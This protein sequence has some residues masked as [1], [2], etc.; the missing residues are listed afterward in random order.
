[1]GIKGTR[2][3]AEVNDESKVNPIGEIISIATCLRAK[4]LKINTMNRTGQEFP[5]FLR[6]E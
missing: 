3:K 2:L 5:G 4:V 1:M 6:S